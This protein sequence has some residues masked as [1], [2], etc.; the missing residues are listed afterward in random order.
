VSAADT[1]RPDTVQPSG[2]RPQFGRQQRTATAS[3]AS[4]AATGQTPAAVSGCPAGCGRTA[5]DPQPPLRRD[6]SACTLGLLVGAGHAGQ[7]DAADRY[8]RSGRTDT[9]RRLPDT[10]SP[11]LPALRTPATAA[12]SSGHCGSGHAGQPAAEASTAAAGVRPERDRKVRHR[13]AR[14]PDRQIRRL[15]I[16]VDLVGSRWIWPAQVGVPRRSR[17]IKTVPLDCLD[18]QG[19]DQA[20]GRQSTTA[21]PAGAPGCQVAPAL[22]WIG[23]APPCYRAFAQLR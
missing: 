19:D 7:V 10:G 16:S 3:A 21:G 15:V 9:G 11:R 20:A 14:P 2:H 12:G 17:R 18:D 1:S 8:R 13:P 5:A 4:S 22:P 6:G 23:G